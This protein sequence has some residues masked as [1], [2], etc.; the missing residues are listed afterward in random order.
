[1]A[2]FNPQNLTNIDWL[3]KQ[4]KN[5]PVC[6]CVEHGNNVEAL[7]NGTCRLC[8]DIEN[9]TKSLEDAAKEL[10]KLKVNDANI[11]SR[12]RN[13]TFAN[14]LATNQNQMMAI[15]KMMSVDKKANIFMTGSTG[16]GKTHLGCSLIHKR[17]SDGDKCYYINYYEII[18]IKF[19]NKHLYDRL[20]T[21]P[22][23]F[24]DEFGL[25]DSD[26]KSDLFLM[27][28]DKRYAN[29]VQT[30]LAT[31]LDSEQIKKRLSDAARSRL[32]EN[33]ISIEFNWDDYR[34]SISKKGE[35]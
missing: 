1:M 31:N 23:L 5:L 15:E 12:Y 29:E 33:F 3:E 9:A 35:E 8:R 14:Y 4:I 13:C 21:V 19:S 26:Y 10:I 28:L 30:V 34:R 16:T 18:D 32:S 2:E 24:I 22:L 27:I 11:P 6:D 7:I 25:Q 20:L 17:L